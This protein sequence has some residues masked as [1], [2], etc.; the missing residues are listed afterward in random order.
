MKKLALALCIVMIAVAGSASALEWEN[1]IGV[2][3]DEA[4]ENFCDA[5][6]IGYHENVAHL[7]V[8]NM[9]VDTINGWEAEIVGENV[10]I[11][12]KTFYGDSFN[13][14]TRPN[15]YIMGLS[16]PLT[17]NTVVLA[18]LSLYVGDDTTPAFIFIGGVYYHTLENKVPALLEYVGPGEA[19][20]AMEAHLSLGGP[21][22]P[23]LIINGECN[24]VDTEDASWDSVKSLYR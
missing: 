24:V 19:G 1:N 9:T 2:Y 6:P 21:N 11:A 3:F 14:G 18:D 15:E 5:L 13:A 12:E 23:V 17:G 22:D 20:V 10:V 4:G 16:A 7:V 8:T